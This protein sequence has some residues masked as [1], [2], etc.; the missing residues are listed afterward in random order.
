MK[1]MG[2]MAL[3]A[4]GFAWAWGQGA[5]AAESVSAYCSMSQVDCETIT[6]AFTADTKIEV[7]FISLSAGE[8]LARIKAERKNPKTAVWI[9]GSADVYIEAAA[10]GLLEPY[11]AK[12]ADK[13][14]A[15]YKDPKNFWTPTSWAPLG[16]ESNKKLLK[17][18]GINA[19]TSWED[20]TNPALRGSIVLAH[21]ASSGTGFA[22]LATLVQAYGEERGFALMQD[23]AKNVV[24]FTKSGGAPANMTALGQA[25][26]AV[27]YVMDIELAKSKGYDVEATFPASGT[28]YGINAVALIANGPKAQAE[29]ARA[30]VDWI[31]TENG[32]KAMSTSF[33]RPVVPGVPNSHAIV[34]TSKVVL[35]KYDA[36]WAGENRARLL[37][38]FES[39]ISSRSQAK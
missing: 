29:T 13:V 3:A 39:E 21:P 11:V 14:D 5:A 31:L 35:M 23:I 6:K 34:D 30:F 9:G 15:K 27:S 16:I 1:R 17:E 18:L 22:V 10:D 24:Q 33:W 7:K 2:A 32:Q 12:G 26:V 25:A 36:F 38:K 28:G 20:L 4:A 8:N 37:Q 19:P